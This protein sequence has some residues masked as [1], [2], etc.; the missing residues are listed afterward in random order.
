MKKTNILLAV[1][2][3]F[4]STL[5]K[6][7]TTQAPISDEFAHTYSIIAID[8]KEGLM[9][10]GVQSHWFNVGRIVPWAKAGVGVI[11]TQSFANTKLG[12]QG[13]TLLEENMHPE[14]VLSKLLTEDEGLDYRQ[15]AILDAQERISAFTG[16]KCIQHASHYIGENY[17]VQANMM[18]NDKVVPSMSL[19]FEERQDL[20]LPE[21]VLEAL[22][23]AQSA[24]GDIRGQQS[25]ALIVVQ[26]S[27]NE[28]EKNKEYEIDLR[29]EDSQEP[30]H[31]LER[32]LKIHRGY[33]LMN[34]AD[35]A[36]EIEDYTTALYLYNKAED[37]MPNNIELQFWKSIAIIS[38]GDEKK[39]VKSLKKVVKGNVNW[40]KLFLQLV[41]EGFLDVSEKVYQ[42][43]EHM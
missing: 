6:S 8:Q 23:S 22:K 4:F 7:Q 28:A 14:E 27:P 24:G 21:R 26:I 2:Y 13:L 1:L 16:E 34:Q 19:T 43:I 37:L 39:G 12:Y 36:L 5:V 38:S 30:L 35:Q 9:A 3:C 31:E 10:V 18:A 41:K 29:V 40:Q 42:E 15:F 20:P 25:V 17:S 32:L 33:E 11:A